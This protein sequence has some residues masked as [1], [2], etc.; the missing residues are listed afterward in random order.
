MAIIFVFERTKSCMFSS[1]TWL[2]FSILTSKQDYEKQTIPEML[3]KNLCNINLLFLLQER[4][5]YD[6]YQPE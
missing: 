3:R 1:T 4:Q 2:W 6:Q 5:R